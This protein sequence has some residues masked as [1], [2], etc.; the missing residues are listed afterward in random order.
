M[1]ADEIMRDYHALCDLVHEAEKAD[2]LDSGD[3]QRLIDGYRE[4]CDELLAE[5]RASRPLVKE[6]R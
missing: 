4:R 3:V 6:E 2:L 5:I 1:T